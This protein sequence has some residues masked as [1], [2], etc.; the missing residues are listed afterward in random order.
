MQGRKTTDY[1]QWMKK[2]TVL[3]KYDVIFIFVLLFVFVVINVE[4]NTI[5]PCCAG[6]DMCSLD[7]A[8]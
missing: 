4:R 6:R 8:V 7:V 5:F 1:M 3:Y 2:E